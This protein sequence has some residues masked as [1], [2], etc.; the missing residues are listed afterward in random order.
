MIHLEEILKKVH[1]EYYK[2][3]EA[4][5]KSRQSSQ[6]EDKDSIRGNKVN[7][8]DLP[9]VK[10]VLPVIKSRVLENIVISFSGVVPTGY[11]L[12]KQRCYL[13]AT[14]LDAK[15]N[16]ELVLPTPEDIEKINGLVATNSKKYEYN[17]DEET[18]SSSGSGKF[19]NAEKRGH[20]FK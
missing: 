19:W 20:L 14:S 4:R 7:E 16:E 11:D 12:K 18:N 13:M 1:D 9:D 5:L 6:I 3:Y 8:A 17:Y 2:I 15:V 10:K